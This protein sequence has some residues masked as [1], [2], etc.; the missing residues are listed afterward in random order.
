MEPEGSLPYSQVPATC[1]YAE[2]IRLG[3]RFTVWMF[4]DNIRVYG[5]EMLAPSPD[6][7]SWRTTPYQLSATIYSPLS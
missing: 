2:S 3:P 4:R 6:P 7:P 5:E 1:L